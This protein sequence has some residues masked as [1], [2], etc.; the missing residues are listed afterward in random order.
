MSILAAKIF[1]R[2]KLPVGGD[3]TESPYTSARR[4]WNSHVGGLVSSRDNARVISIGNMLIALAAVGG[5]SYVALQPKFVPYTIEVDKQG[6]ARG[7]G[8][9]DRMQALKPVMVKRELTKWIENARLVTMDVQLQRNAINAVYA[10]LNAN[11]PAAVKM[12]EWYNASDAAL[13]FNR[14]RTILVSTEV[15]TALPQSESTWEIVWTET[16]RERQGGAVKA[17]FR[18]RALVTY[19]RAEPTPSTTPEDLDKNPLGVFVKDFSWA[20]QN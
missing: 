13:P 10:N 3:A 1:G 14:A 16:E 17:K 12:N 11:D 8:V 19:Y 2:R 18:M 4:E 9:A 15:E 20:K 5:L 7:T 6:N